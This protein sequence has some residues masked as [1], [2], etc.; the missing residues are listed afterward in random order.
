[1]ARKKNPWRKLWR[2]VMLSATFGS[3]GARGTSNPK[4]SGRLFAAKPSQSTRRH[5]VT[6]T[7][8]DL[9]EQ[10]DKQRGKCFWLGIDL[11]PLDIY[12]I[13][14]PLAM[15]V[16]RIDNRRG[17]IKCNIIITCRLANLGRQSCESHVYLEL[18]EGIKKLLKDD[19]N[20]LTYSEKTAILRKVTGAT[21]KGSKKKLKKVKKTFDKIRKTV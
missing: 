2:N 18:I 15:S 1:M 8:H 3:A 13:R 20:P 6:I 21:R 16:D 4:R 7:E 10:F 19:A 17:Y 9:K 14:Y 11:N 12:R 5:E